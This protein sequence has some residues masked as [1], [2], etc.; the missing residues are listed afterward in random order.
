[1]DGFL[2]ALLLVFALAL[3]GRDQWM[4]AIWAG[5]L[6]RSTP[7]LALAIL[8]SAL[9]AAA[10]AWLGAEIAGLLPPRAGQMLVAF[11]LGTAAIELAL[12]ARRAAP[13]EPTRS[14]GALGIVLFA[15]QFG[16]AARFAV[17]ALAAWTAVPAT[18]GL[19]GAVGGAA[20]VALGWAAGA[21][22]LA[23]WR[24]RAVRFVL[25]AGLFVAALLIALD[26]RFA[27]F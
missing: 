14:L 9:S 8:C 23:R 4:V 7:L 18:A 5:T 17:F 12:P 22:R 24:L 26:A 15:R 21:E 13:S 6:G 20:A 10:M 25:A 3:G 19:G 1:M 11:A 2:L 27:A 16:D